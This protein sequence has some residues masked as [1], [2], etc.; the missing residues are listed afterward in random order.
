[1]SAN[2]YFKDFVGRLPSM[3][4]LQ[5]KCV[6]C[7]IKNILQLGQ[8]SNVSWVIHLFNLVLRGTF[9]HVRGSY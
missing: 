8:T 1:M 2:I 7:A 4:Y 5:S 9:F 3:K 6:N